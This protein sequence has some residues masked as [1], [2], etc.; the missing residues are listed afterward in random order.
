MVYLAP[1]WSTFIWSLYTRNKSHWILRVCGRQ[2]WSGIPTLTASLST[3]SAQQA[4][5]AGQVAP[6]AD[7]GRLRPCFFIGRKKPGAQVIGLV[8]AA[9]QITPVETQ[10]WSD[11]RASSLMDI[12]N[13]MAPCLH[14]RNSRRLRE[15]SV[16]AL[17]RAFRQETGLTPM[18]RRSWEEAEEV[19]VHASG[20]GEC[21]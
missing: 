7:P 14:W 10:S 15:V 1:D 17:R 18:Q 12:S 20:Q 11:V 5:I 21:Y 8:N 13:T 16:H 9:T 2:C 19:Q 6:V 3:P 4:Y